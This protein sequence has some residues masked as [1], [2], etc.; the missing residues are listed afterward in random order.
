MSSRAPRCGKEAAAESAAQAGSGS[1]AAE[2][3]AGSGGGED[4]ERSRRDESEAVARELRRKGMFSRDAGSD[5]FPSEVPPPIATSG[6]HVQARD[7]RKGQSGGKMLGKP[8]ETAHGTRRSDSPRRQRALGHLPF[9]KK[10]GG[11]AWGKI[12]RGRR[13]STS[14]VFLYQRSFRLWDVLRPQMG[15]QTNLRNPESLLCSPRCRSVDRG[16]GRP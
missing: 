10:V 4:L 2:E 9:Q 14:A 16:H 8:I 12:L 1:A 11:P 5:A 13:W 3:G 6:R 15:A 7:P